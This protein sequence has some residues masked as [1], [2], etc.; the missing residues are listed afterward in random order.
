MDSVSFLG[1]RSE[2]WQAPAF[3]P[4]GGARFDECEKTANEAQRPAKT[5]RAPVDAHGDRRAP[6]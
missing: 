1:N 4:G 2:P 5:F 3:L 6:D